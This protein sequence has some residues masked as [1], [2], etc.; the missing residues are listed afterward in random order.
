MSRTNWKKSRIFDAIAEMYERIRPNVPREVGGERVVPAVLDPYCSNFAGPDH[1]WQ[2]HLHQILTA[3]YK[4]MPSEKR[5][6]FEAFLLAIAAEYSI[7]TQAKLFQKKSGTLHE[8]K[9][10]DLFALCTIAP[11]IAT[12][13]VRETLTDY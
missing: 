11:H 7:T 13:F 5:D 4:V 8:M 3:L 9:F 1:V 2:I 6:S 10:S 12:M